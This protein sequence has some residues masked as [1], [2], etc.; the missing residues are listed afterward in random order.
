MPREGGAQDFFNVGY[1]RCRLFGSISRR[2]ERVDDSAPADRA[3]KFGDSYRVNTPEILLVYT[4]RIHFDFEGTSCKEI[5]GGNGQ[6][7]TFNLSHRAL[8]HE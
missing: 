6:S 5:I 8:I 2:S 1:S 7:I 4:Y 3:E